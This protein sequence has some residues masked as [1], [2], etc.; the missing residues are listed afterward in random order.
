MLFSIRA[1]LAVRL[2]WPLLAAPLLVAA[3]ALAQQNPDSDPVTGWSGFLGIGPAL[4]P[5][6]AGADSSTIAPFVLG[7]LNYG[8]YFLQL[9]GLTLRA[10]TVPSRRIV[11]GPLV[12]LGSGRDND[13]DSDRV[14]RLDEI[15]ATVEAGGF[16]GIRFGGDDR[17]QGQVELS[18][19]ATGSRNGVLGTAGI[20]YAALRGRSFFVNVDAEVNVANGEYTRTYFGVTQPEALRSGLPAYRP[21]GGLRDAGLGLTAGYQ[22]NQHWGLTGRLSYSYLVGDAADSPIVDLEGSKS[23]LMGGIALSYRF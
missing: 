2:A 20:S 13:V 5:E 19:T 8:P 18:L 6:Y 9:R 17:G 14:A 3:P 4:V 16:V 23:Q 21:K 15:D 22:F 7:D 1:P 10:N 11:A 12:R